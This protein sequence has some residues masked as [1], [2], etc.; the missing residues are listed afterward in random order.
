MV[1]TEVEGQDG[2]DEI[3]EYEDLR[4]VGSS[5]AV[6]HLMAYPIARK[7]PA[8]QAMRVHLEG[9]QQ[10]NFDEGQEEAA[11]ETG[12]KTEL[13]AFFE[14]NATDAMRATPEKWLQYVELPKKF[15]YDAKTKA[16][17]ERKNKSDCIGRVHSVNPVAGDVFYLRLLLHNDHCKGKQSFKD[18][19][20]VNGEV[21][22]SFMETCTKLGILQDDDE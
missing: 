12:R 1:R 19:R 16:W 18:L 15:R 2:R 21:C 8:V 20:T 3:A 13:T 5:E 22:D 17:V 4:S 14:L 11:L 6:W 10:V 9:E 7:H